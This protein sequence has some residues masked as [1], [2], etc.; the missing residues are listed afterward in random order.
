VSASIIVAIIAFLGGVTS[1]T[2]AALWQ[3]SASSATLRREAESVLAKY[4]EPL[5]AAA[6]ELQSRLYNILELKFLE[7]YYRK[8]DD[9]QRR[10]AVKNT[11]YVIGQ[12]FAWSEILRREIQFLSFA[13]SAR[14][15]AV[16]E[17]QRRIVE[18]FQS[19]DPKLGGSLLVWRGEQR[20]IG[21]LMIDPDASPGQCI[22]Y[23]CFLGRAEDD[24]QRWFA[25]LERDIDAIAE[26]RNM[27]LFEI[28]HRLVELIEELDPDQLRYP[29]DTRSKVQ[30][31]RS[32]AP[33]AP[34]S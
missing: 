11:L 18:A 12:Y 13:D 4:R 30:L 14:S 31:P 6:Y 29:A 3:R 19:D 1:A 27:R 9:E 7:K 33:G 23:A 20:A 17:R 8:G 25:R 28:Q 10:Y 16:G 32:A 5:L 34:A 2:V 24:F 22:G 26:E 15:R 21:E